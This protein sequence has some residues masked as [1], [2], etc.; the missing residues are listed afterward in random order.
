M[1]TRF[2]LRLV[3]YVPAGDRV[4]TVTTETLGATIP[5]GSPSV[6]RAQVSQAIYGKLPTIVEAALEYW[7]DADAAWVEPPDCRFLLNTDNDD[8]TDPAGAHSL[9][10]AQLVPWKLAKAIVENPPDLADL[11]NG[12]RPFNSSTPGAIFKTIIDEEQ[13]L[14][15]GVELSYDFTATHDSAG[16]P[17]AEQLTIQY[18]P[19]TSAWVVLRNLID[20]GVVEFS[21]AGR[22]I[23]LWN[24]EHGTDRSTGDAPTRVGRLATTTPVKRS[25][26]DLATDAVLFGEDGFTHSVTNVGAVTELGALRVA[27]QQG[28]VSDEGTAELLAQQRLTLGKEVR[29]QI[30]ASEQ[31]ENAESLPWRHYFP[32]DW[33]LLWLAGDWERVRVAELVVLKNNSGAITVTP[34]LNDR[35][36][37]LLARVAKRTSGIVGGSSASGSGGVPSTED[38]RAPKAPAGLVVGSAGYWSDGGIPLAQIGATWTEVTQGTNDVA[39]DVAA[40]ELWGRPNDGATESNALTTT[41]TNAASASPFNPLTAWLIKVRAQSKNGVWGAF[42]AE[43]A[44]T[45]AQPTFALEAPTRPTGTSNNGVVELR[46]PGTFDTDPVTFPPAHFQQINA[47]MSTAEDGEYSLVGTLFKGSERMSLIGLGVGSVWWFRLSAIDRLGRES[48]LS[49]ATEV[50]VV[51]IDGADLIANTV[52]ANTITAGAIE[53]RHIAAGVGGALDI[54]ANESISLV[55]GEIAEVASDLGDTTSELADLRQR[56]DFT[57]DELRISQPGS[58][59]AFAID[60]ESIEARDGLTVLARWQGGVMYAEQFVGEQ[61]VLGAHKFEAAPAGVKGTVMRALN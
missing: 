58:P 23:H 30:T 56:Y 47:Y 15:W 33:V 18:A 51:G 12:H 26:D 59:L 20:Q 6:L 13:A 11:V 2:D 37:D 17:W 50:E 60:N 48:A 22:T 27:I 44:V 1:L 42:S 14:G 43:V 3:R 53:V 9:Q 24:P 46:W 39:I 7:N 5:N 52:T 34:V 45:M 32:A 49:E 31:A 38:R 54:S 40:Y 25:L 4:G 29:R 57:P 41:T 19:G 61:V 8:D 16:I 10:G 35:F 55:V 21:T 36:L 28:G